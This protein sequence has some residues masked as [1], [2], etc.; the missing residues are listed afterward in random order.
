MLNSGSIP[1]PEHKHTTPA[2]DETS[3]GNSR[4]NRHSATVFPVR[5]EVLITVNM[6]IRAFLVG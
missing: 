1:T 6:K 5:L 4:I 2:Y 3:A